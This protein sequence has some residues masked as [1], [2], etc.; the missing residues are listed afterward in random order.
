MPIAVNGEHTAVSSQARTF[1]SNV[2]K[3]STARGGRYGDPHKKYSPRK[4]AVKEFKTQNRQ[5]CS[6]MLDS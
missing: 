1:C 2:R 3:Q 5:A 4:P 6:M